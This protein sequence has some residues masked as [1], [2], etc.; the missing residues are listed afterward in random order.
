MSR[1]GFQ[2]FHHQSE[3]AVFLSPRVIRN[4]VGGLDPSS[5]ISWIWFLRTPPTKGLNAHLLKA[6]GNAEL[7]VFLSC[8][9]VVFRWSSG[10]EFCL[11]T[12]WSLEIHQISEPSIPVAS[13]LT[14]LTAEI[15]S[16]TTD[17][18]TQARMLGRRTSLWASAQSSAQRTSSSSNSSPIR[19]RRRNFLRNLDMGIR[20]T[21]SNVVLLDICST[22]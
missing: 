12:F 9:S 13:N 11:H 17:S 8:Q 16:F 19:P 1:F 6:S 5:Y 3:D 4:S 15:Y 10:N 14:H 20:D 2:V 7:S 18:R 22:C 21:L